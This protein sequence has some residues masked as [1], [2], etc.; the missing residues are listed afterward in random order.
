MLGESE[1]NW[2][3]LVAVARGMDADPLRDRLRA[4]WEQPVTPE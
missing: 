1:S 2:K 4:T 3:R